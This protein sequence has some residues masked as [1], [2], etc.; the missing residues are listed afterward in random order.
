AEVLLERGW[1]VCVFARRDSEFVQRANANPEW[2]G[3][4]YSEQLDV[5]DS[6]GTKKLVQTVTDHWGQIDL[7]VNNAGISF[8]MLIALA[9]DEYLEAHLDT[10]LSGAIQMTRNVVQGMMARRRGKIINITSV[11]GFRGYKGLAAYSASKAGLDAATRC[12]SRELGPAGITVN[13]IAPGFIPTEMTDHMPEDVRQ[14]NLSNTPLG[15]LATIEDYIPPF[16]FLVGDGSNF[17]T[18]QTLV[19]DGGLTA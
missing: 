17:I 10:N 6:A 2:G 1:R 16:L 4:F 15:R 14:W 8:P 3:R 9:T 13:A 19:V 7:L 12:L 11:V 5:R 18:G